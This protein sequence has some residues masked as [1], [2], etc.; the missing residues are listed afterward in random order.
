MAKME[1]EDGWV[2]KFGMMVSKC[3]SSPNFQG[4]IHFQVT[5]EFSGGWGGVKRI[6]VSIHGIHQKCDLPINKATHPFVLF[7]S[8]SRENGKTKPQEPSLF[9]TPIISIYIYIYTCFFSFFFGVLSHFVNW[10][11]HFFFFCFLP[12]CTKTFSCILVHRTKPTP[13]TKSG[14]AL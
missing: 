6:E 13:G 11:W 10:L 4:L 9:W 14:L 5:C 8:I 2:S 7:F 1:P 3:G 12:W